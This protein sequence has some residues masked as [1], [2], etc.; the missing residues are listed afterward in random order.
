MS[1]GSNPGGDVFLPEHFDHLGMTDVKT[2]GVDRGNESLYSF[3]IGSSRVFYGNHASIYRLF[4]AGN[5]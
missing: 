3:F 1:Q 4:L 2:F 5:H